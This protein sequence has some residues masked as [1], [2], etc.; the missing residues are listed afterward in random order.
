[1]TAQSVA[2]KGEPFISG[3]DN[4]KEALSAF[5]AGISNNAAPAAAAAAPA[6]APQQQQQ[7]REFTLAQFLTP[8]QMVA[9]QL[10]HLQ[11]NAAVPPMLSFYS[12]A[13]F[14]VV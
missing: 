5:V 10:P 8:Q 1:V 6:C 11:W 12:F 3:I 4:S 2:N 14:E 9:L 7:R 13:A